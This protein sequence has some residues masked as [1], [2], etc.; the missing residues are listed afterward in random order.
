MQVT[1]SDWSG[2]RSTLRKLQ[3]FTMGSRMNWTYG[4]GGGG[5]VAFVV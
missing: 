4:G 5:D 1:Q 3:L 2:Q